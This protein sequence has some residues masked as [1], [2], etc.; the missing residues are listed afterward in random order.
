MINA[1]IIDAQR[2]VTN[3]IVVN[4][5]SEAPGSVE[6]PSWVGIGMSIDAPEPPA[7]VVVPQSVTPRQA[8]LALSQQG[9][10]A[11]VNTAVAAADDATK[12]TWEFALSVDRNSPLV[13]TL[14]AAVS[15]TDSQIDDLFILAA[16]L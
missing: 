9:K 5:L 8:R 6:C 2:I 11:A 15:L 10:L 1:A 4:S 13:A 12:I 7:P 14:G 16:T 3:V